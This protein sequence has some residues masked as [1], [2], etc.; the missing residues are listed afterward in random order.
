MCHHGPG[1]GGP[2]AV[3]PPPPPQSMMGGGGGHLGSQIGI[4]GGGIGHCGVG[5]A[6]QQSSVPPPPPPLCNPCSSNSFNSVPMPGPSS[7]R[8]G[9]RTSCPVHSPFRVRVPNGSI[10]PGHQVSHIIK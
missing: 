6:G 10:C 1:P 7:S 4:G 2:P 3:P 9:P 8:W 5:G